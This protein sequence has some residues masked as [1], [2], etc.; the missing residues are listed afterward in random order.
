MVSLFS[1]FFA[2]LGL[3]LLLFPVQ[4]WGLSVAERQLEEAVWIGPDYEL[5]KAINDIGERIRVNPYSAFDHYLLSQAYLRLFNTE[6]TNL[7]LIQKANDLAQQSIE[8]NPSADYGTVALANMLSFMGQPVRGIKYIGETMKAKMHKNSWR[9][10]FMLGQLNA[11]MNSTET[12]LLFYKKAL[13]QPEAPREIIVPFV[14][15]KLKVAYGQDELTRQLL[16]WN[17]LHPSYHF[18]QEIAVSYATSKKYLASDKM[19]KKINSESH[20]SVASLT[21]HA[22]LLYQ[23]LNRPNE[24]LISLNKAKSMLAK[25]DTYRQ[26]IVDLHVAAA[27]LR[28]NQPNKAEDIYHDLLVKN[29]LQED[30]FV[31]VKNSYLDVKGLGGYLK[32]LNQ[33]SHE[34]GSATLYEDI[35]RVS[36]TLNQNVAAVDAFRKSILLN[37]KSGE[38]Y[39]LLGL[40]L[41][42]IKDYQDALRQFDIATKISPTSSSAHY[43]KACMLSILRR[44]DE[45]VAAL[46]NALILDPNLKGSASQD[47]DLANIRGTT[48]FQKIIAPTVVAH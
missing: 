2:V 44:T 41:Y 16:T 19:F 17:D 13:V 43:N 38:L 10:Y 40:S 29:N 20:R 46:E 5:S 33:L 12:Q 7:S 30:L 34:V 47:G 32:L 9:I 8:L 28:T 45:A 42:K 11:E 21:N 31:L 37:P 36:D 4:S 15:E 35:G 1:K 14:I 39:N 24:A 6:P 27:Y 25:G 22:I 3:A 48:K 23:N 18:V 26:T